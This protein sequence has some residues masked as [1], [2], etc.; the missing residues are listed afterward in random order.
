M[1]NLPYNCQYS[2]SKRLTLIACFLLIVAFCQSALAIN[3]DSIPGQQLTLF[4]PGQKSMEWVLTKADHGGAKNIRKG[5]RCLECHADE[6][7][8]IGAT[9][10]A[11][12]QKLSALLTGKPG[13]INALVKMAYDQN[14]FHVQIS[15]KDG[16]TDS[17]KKMD[18]KYA[19][20]VTLML[21]DGHVRAATLA[22]CWATC[23]DDAIDMPSAPQETEISKYLAKS[24]TKLK[25]SGGGE[26]YKKPEEL[27]K[28]MA[29]GVFMEYWQARLN[30]G[31]PPVPIDGY[32]LD[33]RHTNDTPVV[34][35]KAEYKDGKWIVEF[36]RK[37]VIDQPKHKNI[38]AGQTYTI[39]FAIHDDFANHRHHFVSFGRSFVLDEGDADIVVKHL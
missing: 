9:Q 16:K 35:T 33:K 5:K 18:A 12:S 13:S 14:D 7:Q 25:R 39:G 36:S 4:Y 1:K 21:D 6:E 32:I 24:R 10:L 8:E 28:L 29:D 3:W 2:R 20:R 26:S 31:Q 38:V 30:V 27:S 19:S 37:R 11:D 17:A 23:H 22:G 15:W 34:A